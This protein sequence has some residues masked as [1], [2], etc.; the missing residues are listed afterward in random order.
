M[1]C[2]NFFGTSGIPF[3]EWENLA[4][5][6]FELLKIFIKENKFKHYEKDSRI[7]K[8]ARQYE[9]KSTE[10]KNKGYNNLNNIFHEG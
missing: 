7:L 9:I 3:K 2:C 4:K 5:K 1:Y 8:L 6:E 10:L